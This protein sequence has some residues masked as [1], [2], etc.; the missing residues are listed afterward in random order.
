MYFNCEVLVGVGNE[1]LDQSSIA[2]DQVM[3]SAV[4]LSV[5]KENMVRTD[6][7]DEDFGRSMKM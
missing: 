7:A 5:C 4:C 3:Q 6:D 2:S 1:D